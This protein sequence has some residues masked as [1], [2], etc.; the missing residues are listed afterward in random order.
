VASLFLGAAIL[1]GACSGDPHVLPNGAIASPSEQSSSALTKENQGV[2]NPTPGVDTKI[3]KSSRPAVSATSPAF[4]GQEPGSY[5]YKVRWQNGQG[6]L[7]YD[8]TESRV[9][10]QPQLAKQGW[11][12]LVERR[13]PS[14]GRGSV[15]EDLL[16]FSDSRIVLVRRASYREDEPEKQ[17][18]CP[19]SPT[20]IVEAPVSVGWST[21]ISG[22]CDG[23][24][25]VIDR[26]VE[27]SEVL[28]IGGRAISTFMIK[29]VTKTTISGSSTRGEVEETQ[30]IAPDLGYQVVKYVSLTKGIELRFEGILSR[31]PKDAA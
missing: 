13:G 18:V 5:V 6:G 9:V 1:L 14:V 28:K 8:D 10:R 20:L 16:L 21:R 30:W 25:F 22:K 24:E 15:E 11:R 3:A 31:L 27:R 29:S 12:Q 2:S 7:W 19:A 23:R 17:Y 4:W 26:M